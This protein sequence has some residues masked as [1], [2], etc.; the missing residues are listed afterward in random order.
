MARSKAKLYP[1]TGNEFYITLDDALKYT[2]LLSINYEGGSATTKVLYKQ[3]F[4]CN[5]VVN[6]NSL[7]HNSYL[8]EGKLF[9]LT[10]CPN[11]MLI[12]IKNVATDSALV[13]FHASKDS[14]I[15]FAST[16]ISKNEVSSRPPN[17]IWSLKYNS[18]TSNKKDLRAKDFFRAINA[19]ELSLTAER[20]GDKVVLKI[21]ESHENS[22][23]KSGCYAPGGF[24]GG[25]G[26]SGRVYVLPSYSFHAQSETFF[27]TIM[28]T[29][30]SPIILFQDVMTQNPIN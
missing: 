6:V 8:F 23:S 17:I 12:E 5:Q 11:D 7:Q 4:Y 1:G 19:H 24:S 22:V 10:F 30:E 13:S 20:V 28:K 18:N 21:G 14:I 26:F 9:Q 2:V 15:A 3:N 27:K 25:G 16:E 29:P